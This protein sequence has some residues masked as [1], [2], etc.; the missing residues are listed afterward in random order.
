MTSAGTPE[1]R[2]G[3]A[4]RHEGHIDHLDHGHLLH[5]EDGRIVEHTIAVSSTNPDR[6]DPDHRAIAEPGHVHGPD[7][8]HEQV[9]HGDHIDF[10]V[11]GR[12]QH[13]HGDHID[14]HGPLPLA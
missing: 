12:L 10:L 1:T 7:C 8:G 3:V 11:D 13:L 5:E 2:H 6:C 9:P 4:V 14:D